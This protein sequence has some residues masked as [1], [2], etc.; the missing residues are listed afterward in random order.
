M[1]DRMLLEIAES[2]WHRFGQADE[3]A[4]LVA[5]E[6]GEGVVEHDTRAMKCWRICKGRGRLGRRLKCQSGAGSYV[7]S[8]V[9]AIN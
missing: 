1:T 8:D 9:V 6:I 7:Q 2:T 3:P 4:H 5:L